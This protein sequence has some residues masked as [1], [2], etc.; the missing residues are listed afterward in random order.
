LAAA[1]GVYL[2]AQFAIVVA[3]VMPISIKPCADPG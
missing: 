3:P 2:T 1:A